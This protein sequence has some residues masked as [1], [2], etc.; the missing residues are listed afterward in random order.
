MRAGERAREREREG[1]GAWDASLLGVASVY[2]VQYGVALLFIPAGMAAAGAGGVMDSS[3][4]L[5]HRSHAHC[6][7]AIR[8][9]RRILR[10]IFRAFE[11][12]FAD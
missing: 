2:G 12:D 8:I 6:L 7:Y 10:Q 4:N 1:G 5:L 9:A 11:Q 3:G